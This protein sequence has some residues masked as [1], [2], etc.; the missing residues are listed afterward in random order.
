VVSANEY[1]CAHRAHINFG[2]LTSFLTYGFNLFFGQ[3]AEAGST[4]YRKK[5]KRKGRYVDIP[6][7][8]EEGVWSQLSQL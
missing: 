1:S 6:A 2:D 7:M 5:R 4:C 8:L 3:L